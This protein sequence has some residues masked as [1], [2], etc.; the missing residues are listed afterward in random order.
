MTPKIPYTM[1]YNIASIYST[2]I[3]NF[4]LINNPIFTLQYCINLSN[5]FKNIQ[6]Y[7]NTVIKW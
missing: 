2:E 4:H 6:I 1:K 5:T 7:F 3:Q